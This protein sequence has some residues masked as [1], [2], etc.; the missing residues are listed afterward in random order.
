MITQFRRGPLVNKT[1][2]RVM[3]VQKNAQAAKASTSHQY[4]RGRKKMQARTT[5]VKVQ[6]NKRAVTKKQVHMKYKSESQHDTPTKKVHNLRVLI[7]KTYVEEESIIKSLSPKKEHVPIYRQKLPE[8]TKKDAKDLYEFSDSSP[9]QKGNKQTHRSSIG[10]DKDTYEILKKIEQK[11]A[12]AAAQKKRKVVKKKVNKKAYEDIVS[13]I[14]KNVSNKILQRHDMIKDTSSSKVPIHRTPVCTDQILTNTPISGS[15]TSSNL[16]EK[17]T[18][19]KPIVNNSLET[20]K[21][22][23]DNCF[24]KHSTPIHKKKSITSIPNCDPLLPS[25]NIK[26]VFTTE[27]SIVNNLTDTLDATINNCFGFDAPAKTPIKILSNILLNNESPIDFVT[28]HPNAN[29]TLVECISSPWRVNCGNIKHNPHFLSLK[30]NALPCISQE[31]VLEHTFVEKF[32]N[33]SPK[34]ILKKSPQKKTLHQQSILDFI[35]SN[36]D[37]EN[38]AVQGSLY[39]YEA[40]NSP[41]KRGSSRKYLGDL[42]NISNKELYFGFDES[43][44][45]N[46]VANNGQV[47]PC[48][49]DVS[50]LKR[51]KKKVQKNVSFNEENEK[52]VVMDGSISVIENSAEDAVEDCVGEVNLFED[53]EEM[54]TNM[55]PP[56]EMSKRRKRLNSS[57]L[58]QTD[59][60][61][62]KRKVKKTKVDVEEEAWVSEFNKMCDEVQNHELE[63]E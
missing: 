15:L 33:V 61:R 10:F 41:V 38:E 30:H 12:K 18:I 19:E 27:N 39:D 1:N 2:I 28:R 7:P 29:S 5:P 13:N 21:T 48:R 20:T 36:V 57:D 49:F 34:I 4:R 50:K 47:G 46:E 42:T 45:V 35:D 24:A 8:D 37:K 44:D 63:F 26:N 23:T 51:Y 59:W 14:V 32:K 3:E 54:L 6:V 22:S 53:P 52:E 62:K 16:N 31:S 9:L 25:F 56:H 11:E 17:I 40:F 60:E 43:G 58:D 55:S